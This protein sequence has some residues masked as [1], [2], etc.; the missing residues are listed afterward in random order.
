MMT[1]E[2]IKQVFAPDARLPWMKS[3]AANPFPVKLNDGVYRIYF[4]CRDEDN[5]SHIAYVDIDFDHD[6]QLLGISEEPVLMPGSLGLFDDSGVAMGC[7][8]N[9]N[10]CPHLYYLGWNLKQTVPWMNTIGL[11]KFNSESQQF[12]KVSRAPI[13]DRSHED[14]YSLSYPFV[15]FDAGKYKMWYGSNLSWGK[16]SYSMQHVIKYA[17]SDDGIHWQRNHTIAIPLQH[18]GEYAISKPFVI[19]ENNTYYMWYTYRG[20]G[21]I[22]TYRIGFAVSKDGLHWKRKDEEMGLEIS[23]ELAWD[24][25]MLCYPSLL[26]HREHWYLLYNGND[27]GQ[28]GFGLA[29]LTSELPKIL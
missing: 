6:F 10:A 22:S 7:M 12:E 3:H 14:P 2:K 19:K 26:K 27:Y 20:H 23:N 24:S 4:T 15:L 18:E 16:E 29:R 9:I 1:W 5:R 25:H 11:A 8:L 21:P 28:T 13:L 17:E